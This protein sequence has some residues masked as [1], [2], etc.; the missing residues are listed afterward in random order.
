MNPL[1][2]LRSRKGFTLVEIM[3]AM[4]V[5]ALMMAGLATIIAFVSKTWLDGINVVDNFTKARIMLNLL[6]R[7][8]QMM[9]MRRDVCAFV[10]NNGAPACAFYT[11]VQGN[12]NLTTIDTRSLSLVQYTLATTPVTTPPSPPPSS[13]T[14]SGLQRI[15]LG[16]TFASGSTT[17]A[18]GYPLPALPILPTTTYP[19]GTSQA[20]QTEEIGSGV[21]AF[22]WQFVDGTGTLHNPT[23]NASLPISSTSAWSY[24]YSNPPPPANYRAV[25]VSLAVMSN[26]AYQL[27]IKTQK[28][29]TIAALF[30]T[31]APTNQTYARVWNTYLANPS[32]STYQ[33]LPAPLR[34]SGSILVFQRYIPLPV[35]APSS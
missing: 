22:Q 25:I 5:L 32:D 16:L 30:N 35:T 33:S 19:S 2:P 20:D 12:Q 23:S 6:D 10:D 3:V 17:M 29:G 1:A 4:V 14:S 27:A 26:N 11:K 18:L 31:G 15:A 9:V 21:I 28:L 7:D 8:V 34:G 13:M 24:D